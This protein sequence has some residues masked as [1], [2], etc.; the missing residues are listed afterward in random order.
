M[1][2]S[3]KS[4]WFRLFAAGLV[5]YGLISS[6]RIAQWYLGET[7]GES[8]NE[9]LNKFSFFCS[10]AV[11]DSVGAGCMVLRDVSGVVAM[12]LAAYCLIFSERLSA[13]IVAAIVIV[14]WLSLII[15]VWLV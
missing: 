2:W 6:F 7:P 3:L 12:L 13:Q 8:I 4:L 14:Y 5:A 11:F 9:R 15:E 10:R 1:R